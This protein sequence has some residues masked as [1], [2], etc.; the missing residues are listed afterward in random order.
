MSQ[1][2]DGDLTALECVCVCVYSFLLPVSCC[3]P[4]QR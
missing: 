1:M 3:F 4:Q 2:A